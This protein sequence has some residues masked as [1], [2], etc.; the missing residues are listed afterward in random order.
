MT[1]KNTTTG[2]L[3]LQMAAPAALAEGFS[4]LVKKR[5]CFSHVNLRKPPP[6]SSDSTVNRTK[7]VSKTLLTIND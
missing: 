7:N 1:P 5:K 6:R 3:A 2:R 4:R